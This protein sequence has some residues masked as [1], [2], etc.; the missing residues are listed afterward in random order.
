MARTFVAVI[1]IAIGL[2]IP[3]SASADHVPGATYT[4]PEY[5]SY[6]EAS[7]SI[8]V[9]LTPDLCAAARKKVKKLKA[10]YKTAPSAKLKKKLKKAKAVRKEEC[11]GFPGLEPGT[12]TGTHVASIYVDGPI[13]GIDSDTGT[14]CEALGP[15]R[16]PVS[17]PSGLP[18]VFATESGTHFWELTPQNLATVGGRDITGRFLFVQDRQVGR[19]VLGAYACVA[20]IDWVGTR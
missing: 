10:L 13:T 11:V 17:L 4:G 3:A 2:V 14:A 12:R 8:S 15:G 1:A 20:A 18:F 6:G 19:L 7:G 16:I 5:A 9:T